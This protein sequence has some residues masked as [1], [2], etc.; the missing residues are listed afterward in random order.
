M[1]ALLAKGALTKARLTMSF[2]GTHR[3]ATA[4]TTTRQF[5][6]QRRRQLLSKDRKIERQDPEPAH[7]VGVAGQRGC[8]HLKVAVPAAQG[9]VN[10]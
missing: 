7:T 10:V 8:P 1:E 5:R 2:F 4:A 3:Q 9:H 6:I